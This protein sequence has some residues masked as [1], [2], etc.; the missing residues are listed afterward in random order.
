MKATSAPLLGM[1]SFLSTNSE[2]SDILSPLDYSSLLRP[3]VLTRSGEEL[4]QINPRHRRSISSDRIVDETA[5]RISL[6]NF[7]QQS[8]MDAFEDNLCLS[9]SGSMDSFNEVQ[10]GFN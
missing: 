5:E 6:V 7:R 1:D 8:S 10:R 9:K 2:D 3:V 4:E